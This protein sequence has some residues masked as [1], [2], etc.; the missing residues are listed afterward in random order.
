MAQVFSRIS[1]VR[2]LR[3]V[4]V[5]FCSQICIAV[6]PSRIK[7]LM[8]RTRGMHGMGDA[9]EP[10][11]GWGTGGILATGT[12]H[13]MVSCDS[14][15]TWPACC[16]LPTTVH[17][18]CKT[19]PASSLLLMAQLVAQSTVT[20]TLSSIGPVFES[21][22]GDSFLLLAVSAHHHRTLLDS[23]LGCSAGA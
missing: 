20:V 7:E 16:F 4:N 17:M 8:V 6:Q 1:Y 15:L 12:A 21:Q 5:G 18:C 10:L 11:T 3:R 19:A 13:C 22:S 23:T 14:Y 9:R 2:R